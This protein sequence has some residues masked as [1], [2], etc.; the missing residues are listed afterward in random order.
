M[1]RRK[2]SDVMEQSS[3]DRWAALYERTANRLQNAE[4]E[5]RRLEERIRWLQ[6]HAAD[7]KAVALGCQTTYGRK[8]LHSEASYAS[9]HTAHPDACTMDATA[10]YHGSND[11]S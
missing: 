3:A 6:T 11:Y 8:S 1:P 2:E 10:R 7:W 5:I 4:M 9:E